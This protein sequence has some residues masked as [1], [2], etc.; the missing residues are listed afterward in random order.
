[1]RTHTSFLLPS[2]EKVGDEAAR[3][4]GLVQQRPMS[5]RASVSGIPLIRLAPRAAF[6]PERRRQ[7]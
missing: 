7:R 1:M 4:R 5:D 6:S 3:M 2:G